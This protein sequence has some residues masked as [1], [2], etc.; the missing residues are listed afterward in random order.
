MEAVMIDWFGFHYDGRTLI[1]LKTEMWGEL[2][3]KKELAV[4]PRKK[5]K[6]APTTS[7]PVDNIVSPGSQLT[8]DLHRLATSLPAFLEKAQ[9]TI[10]ESVSLYYTAQ[11]I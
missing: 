9:Q 10:D 5:S 3:K 11:V 7:S 6:P 1:N 4:S 8:Q 2:A